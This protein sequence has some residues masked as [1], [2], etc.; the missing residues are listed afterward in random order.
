MKDK[1]KLDNSK[2]NFKVTK[3]IKRNILNLKK[4]INIKSGVINY[5]ICIPTT[6]IDNCCNLEQVSFTAYQIAKTAVLFNIQEIIVLDMSKDKKHE[7]QPRSKETISDCLLLA[8]LLQYFVTPPN[9]VDVTFKKKHRSYLKYAFTFPPLGQLPFMNEPADETYIEGLSIAEQTSEKDI[10]DENLTSLVYIGKNNTIKL[11]SQNIPK[12][13]RVTV[14][15][16]RKKVVSPRDAY[17]DTQLGY[18]VRMASSLDEVSGGCTETL[19]VNSGD[20]HYDE[21][22]S[23][24][25]KAETKLPYITAIQ[26]GSALDTPCNILLIFGKWTHLKRCLKRS[27]LESSALHDFFSGQ[28]QFPGTVPQGKLAIQD[29]LQIALT[30]LQH[31]AS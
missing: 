2:S 16:L 31:W 3:K 21:T 7:R 17:K 10:S 19:W 20:Y 27:D 30:M 28:L 12:T 4:I 13:V 14:D 24:Y 9:L 8:T 29:S 23:K 26:K 1:R 11:S 25:R 15:T 22:L 18:Y 6:I 5:S